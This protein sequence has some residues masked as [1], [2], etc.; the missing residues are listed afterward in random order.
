MKVYFISS[1]IKKRKSS[2]KKLKKSPVKLSRKLKKSIKKL[3]RKI[4]KSIRKSP[5]KMISKKNCKKKLSKKIKTNMDEWKS[6]RY[7]SQEQA[8]AV[9]YSQIKRKYPDCDRYF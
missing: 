7:V 5:K 8:L 6:G 3:S 2:V 9:S 1:P 4:K